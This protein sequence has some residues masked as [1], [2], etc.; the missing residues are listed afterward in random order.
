[1]Y[2]NDGGELASE[3]SDLEDDQLVRDPRFAPALEVHIRRFL[4]ETLGPRPDLLAY[5]SPYLSSA[6]VVQVERVVRPASRAPDYHDSR[7]RGRARA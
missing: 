4:K 2:G 7:R 3:G 1:M 5:L 6:E